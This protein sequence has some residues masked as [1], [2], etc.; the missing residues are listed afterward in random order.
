VSSETTPAAA[1]RGTLYIVSAPSGAG[2]TSLVKALTASDPDVAVSVS[3]TTR[4]PRPGERDGVDYHFVDAETFAKMERAG[5]FLEHATVFDNHYGTA[6]DE[7]LARLA[8]GGDVILEIDWQGARQVRAAL[9]GS[10]GIF[11]LPPS[12]AVL[13]QRLRARGQDSEAVILR[14]MQDAVREMSHYEEYDY[15]VVNEDFDRAL[16]DLS[17]ILRAR[18]LRLAPQRARLAGALRDLLA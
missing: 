11:V 3:H 18:R 9:P 15:L 12:R 5:L 10:V 8:G 16:A 2:K 17:A 14:R 6:R 1:P 7:V 13:E 4:A